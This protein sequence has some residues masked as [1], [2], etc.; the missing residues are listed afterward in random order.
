MTR[1][2][3]AEVAA[4]AV[5]AAAAGCGSDTQP[6]IPTKLNDPPGRDSGGGKGG[7]PSKGRTAPDAAGQ[8]DAD[9]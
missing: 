9:A 2:I 5:A 4:A 6:T 7:K 3:F 1:R 8:S